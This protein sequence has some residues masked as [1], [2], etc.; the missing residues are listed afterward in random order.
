MTTTNLVNA[1]GAGSGLDTASIIDAIVAAERAPK[2]SQIDRGLESS[3]AKISAY[4]VVTSALESL[5]AAF[6][7]LKDL[8]D[9]EDYSVVSTASG[10]FDV[11][12]STGAVTG[13]HTL[14]VQALAAGDKWGS[15]TFSSVDTKLNGG[16]S[17]LLSVN[18]GTGDPPKVSIDDPTPSGV[19]SAINAADIGLSASLI[20]LG[21]GSNPFQIVVSGQPGADNAFSLSSA[22]GDLSFS[23]QLETAS[24]SRLT[25]DG[26]TIERSTNQIDDILSGITLN[27]NSVTS[28]V[29]SFSVSRDTESVKSSLQSLVS[30]YNDVQTIFN[31]LKT[32]ADGSDDELAG[33]LSNDS[34]F[35]SIRDQIREMVTAVSTTPSGSIS[36]FADIGVSITRSGTLEIDDDRLDS[37]L[38]T[39]FSDVVAALSAGTSNQTEIGSASRGLAGDASKQIADLLSSGGTIKTLVSNAEER[40]DEYQ[41]ALQD[42]NT[43]MESIR[44]RYVKQFAAMESLVDEMNNTKDYL[45]TQL[46]NLPF[47]KKD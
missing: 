4:G 37:T 18:D 43:R 25:V 19:V 14:D 33:A 39:S 16:N 21:Y 41:D 9:F 26:V 22:S 1:L 36:Y 29:E 6:G 30:T 45:K 44:S 28:S 15:N 38:S 46:E 24:N 20:N 23:V 34:T 17:F 13:Q 27:L 12:S 32:P 10:E 42:L 3:D 11:T 7:D 8:S 40:K 31:E 35:R 47:T 5:R 2:Q